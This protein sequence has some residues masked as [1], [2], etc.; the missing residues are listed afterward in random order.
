MAINRLTAFTRKDKGEEKVSAETE[1]TPDDSSAAPT[2]EIAAL[3]LDETP[4]PAPET[5]ASDAT[6][7][8]AETTDA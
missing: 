1:A 6:A 2:E 7:S 4:A 8:P 3:A 5:A